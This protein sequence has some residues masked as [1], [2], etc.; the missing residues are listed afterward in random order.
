MEKAKKRPSGLC[1]LTPQV[2]QSI[3]YFKTFT[4]RD[5]V[6]DLGVDV[7]KRRRVNDV[8]AVL[9]GAGFIE[10]TEQKKHYKFVGI[11]G[12]R[13]LFDSLHDKSSTNER[14]DKKHVLRHYGTHLVRLFTQ[15]DSWETKDLRMALLGNVK[16]RRFYDV[17][18]VF[19]GVG[20]L[21]KKKE[22]ITQQIKPLVPR[23]TSRVV[24]TVSDEDAV[25][26][27]P[28]L[29]D[30]LFPPSRNTEVITF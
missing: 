25:A 9:Y 12:T 3:M 22:T 19:Y 6:E 20:L 28:E 10:K 16:D 30:H 4:C 26:I 21:E 11:Q 1:G 15:K 2:I 24:L 17:I 18:S 5:V 27:L 23:S 29:K 14:G 8:L 13:N 7:K